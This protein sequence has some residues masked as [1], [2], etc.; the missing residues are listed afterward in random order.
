MVAAVAVEV[1]SWLRSWVVA[2]RSGSAV[3]VVV[4]VA[5]VAGIGVGGRV[6]IPRESEC[7]GET[8]ILR[9]YCP[10]CGRR[11]TADTSVEA[12]ILQ[13]DR[14]AAG[15]HR[16]AERAAIRGA[17]RYAKS[18]TR[19]AV[20]WESWS[21]KTQTTYDTFKEVLAVLRRWRR[22]K[23]NAGDAMEDINAAFGYLPEELSEEA[24]K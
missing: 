11:L 14:I 3:R 22:H 18:K 19:I 23:V 5:G 9:A 1:A 4:V 16:A 15:H 21:Y 20:K 6:V 24:N 10:R 2:G 17:D 13:L 8:H 7:C 12:L